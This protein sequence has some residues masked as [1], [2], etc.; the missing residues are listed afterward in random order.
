VIVVP[1]GGWPEV[2]TYNTWEW[3]REER[4]V[5]P[6]EER[7]ELGESWVEETVHSSQQKDIDPSVTGPD[8]GEE[9]KNMRRHGDWGGMMTEEAWW[10]RHG[11][12]G[13]MVSHD[14]WGGMVT[15]EAWWVMMI[16]EACWLRRHGDWGAEKAEWEVQKDARSLRLTS[17]DSLIFEPET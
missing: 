15:E 3:A 2:V 1:R 13:G 5:Q 11:D 9:R 7:E 4:R 6:I 8:M 12:W 17:S 16:E 14:D 10:L